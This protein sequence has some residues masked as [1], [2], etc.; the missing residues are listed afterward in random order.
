[1]AARARALTV[2]GPFC[3]GYYVSYLLRS[4]NA[5]IAPELSREL[6]LGPAEL[7]FLTSTYFLTFATA[8]LPVGVALDRFGPRKVVA[9]LMA[10]G[11]LGVLL[12]ASA[13]SF[14]WL[15]VGRALLGLGVAA[16]LM[17]ALKA[18]AEA[19]P[20][21]RQASLTGIIMA[22]G[23]TGALSAS[24][25]LEALLPA[26]GWRG[27]LLGVAALSATAALLIAVAG[28]RQV[29]VSTPRAPFA[30]EVRALGTV[31]RSPA[32][33]RY[34]PQAFV[35]TGTFMAVQGLWAVP[36]AMVVEGRSR[37]GAAALLL[38]LSAGML[39]GQLSI[40]AT[41]SRLGRAGLE[42]R[43]LMLTGLALALGIQALVIAR[44][45]SGPVPWFAFGFVSSASAQIYGVA[46]GHFPPAL[47]GRVSTALNN[48]AFLGAFLLQWGI[49]AAVAALGAMDMSPARAFQVTL[50][51]LWLAQVLA[52]AWSA[53]TQ[54]SDA[55]P[56]AAAR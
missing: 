54:S 34:A 51:A 12:F 5:V 4:V 31:L 3:V 17:G 8:Q 2:L 55:T 39:S 38:A 42:R 53:R 33:W 30:T 52:V 40:G 27:A 56:G 41:A 35:F 44:V 21:A 45:V 28:P 29:E 13:Q 50:A 32:F 15:A 43:H 26:L 49:G 25:P 46:S 1:M 37:T 16:C 23:A 6:G 9:S 47:S 19:F 20:A 36:W 11:T 14:V 48:L 24:L 22:A 7:G 18:A 10:V